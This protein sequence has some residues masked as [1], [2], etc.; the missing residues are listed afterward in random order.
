MKPFTTL[1][2]IASGALLSFAALIGACEVSNEDVAAG[3][4]DTDTDGDC[5]EGTFDCAGQDYNV[6]EG[7]EWTLVES[8]E[9]VCVS[10]LG[11]VECI[12]GDSIC[13]LDT[14]LVCD[15]D[16]MGYSPFMDCAEVSAVCVDGA[17]EGGDPCDIAAATQ[18]NIG[19]EYWA[20]DLDNAQNFV[21]DAAEGQFAVAV[22]NIGNSISA[23]VTVEINEAPQGEP[24][25]LSVVE[26]H[27]VEPLGLYIFRL[28]RRDVDGG[29]FTDN[30]VDDGPQTRL[31]S[32]AFRITSDVPVVAYQ[33]NTLDQQFSNDA[34]LLL[35]TSALGK[36]HIV[37]GYTPSGPVASVTKN[38]GYVTIVGVQEATTVTVTPSF[39]IDLGEG[40][41]AIE[42][43]TPTDFVIGP[44]DVINLETRFMTLVDPTIPDL[45]GTTVISD[46]PVAV[47]FGT[48]LSLVSNTDI[49]EDSCCAEH[50]EE[51]ILPSAAMAQKFVVSHSAI[52]SEG[53]PEQDY[54][55]I[56][57]YNGATVTTSLP[58]PNDSFTLGAGEYRELFTNTGFTV[59]ASEGYLHVAQFLVA[60]GDVPNPF[61]PAGDSSLMY[62]P[63][64]DQRRGL[65]VFTT[66]EGF[67]YNAVVVSKPQGAVATI[68]DGLDVD[69]TC[70]GPRVDG[71]IDGITYEAW[72]CEVDDGAHIVYSGDDPEDATIP[73]AVYFY[74]YYNAGSISY[75]AGS[76]LR[77]T[78]PIVIE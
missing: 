71:E 30:H 42:A 47:F 70:V 19:C 7:G 48:D 2:V 17:C 68:D 25:S 14:V 28:P 3:D 45:S 41:D 57:S 75:P 67:A 58:S 24:L 38:R 51:Q 31:S 66:G 44:F 46:G 64:V 65:Y 59:E 21:D 15:D 16:G 63:A 50:L 73:I 11:C 53:T 34:S 33:F 5:E 9:A 20:V 55:R 35:P 78:N 13:E 22:A 72:E 69:S 36:D 6:C 49:Y 77:H 32:D 43:G 61:G 54:Y 39:D 10:Y 1:V 56:M 23:N 74:S 27:A 12:P 40:I 29:D 8:C 18:S 37:V 4:T 76:D 52:R 60:G 26:T 62:I